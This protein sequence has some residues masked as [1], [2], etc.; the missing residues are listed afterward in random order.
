MN[1]KTIVC[2]IAAAAAVI[3]AVILV[4]AYREKM[5]VLAEKANAMAKEYSKKIRRV[6]DVVMEDDAEPVPAAE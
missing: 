2:I 1:K 4:I 6:P 5:T 3:A